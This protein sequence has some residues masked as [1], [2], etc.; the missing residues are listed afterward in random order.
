MADAS[1]LSPTELMSDHE[2]PELIVVSEDEPTEIALSTPS[3]PTPASLSPTVSYHGEPPWLVN[4][5]PVGPLPNWDSDSDMEMPELPPLIALPAL[6][7]PAPAMPQVPLPAAP[8]P[9]ELDDG[10]NPDDDNDDDSGDDSGDDLAPGGSG[11]LTPTEIYEE[12]DLQLP[13]LE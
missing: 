7:L 6:P 11:D 5:Q 13:D 8:A 10:L 9:P 12:A 4:M 3:T 1:P 2:M